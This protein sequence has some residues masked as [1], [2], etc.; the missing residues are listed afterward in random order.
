M[1]NE[2]QLYSSGVSH[3]DARQTKTGKV[4][5][6]LVTEDYHIGGN[7]L[8]RVLQCAIGITDKYAG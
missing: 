4:R 5:E 1:I 8:I 2:L 6:K 3:C 7:A